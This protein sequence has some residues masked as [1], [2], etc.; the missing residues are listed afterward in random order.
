MVGEY[1][2]FNGQRMVTLTANVAGE[3]L[4]RALTR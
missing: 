3:D 2:R 4:G 1:D